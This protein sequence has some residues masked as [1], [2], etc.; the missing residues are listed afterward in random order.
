M[1]LANDGAIDGWCIYPDRPDE[2]ATVEFLVN[3]KVV[4]SMRA[5][6]LRLDRRDLGVGDG[7]CGFSFP[8]TRASEPDGGRTI[9]EVRERRLNTFI[10]RVILGQNNVALERRL[11]AAAS[12]LTAVEKA[13]VN[14]R[15]NSTLVDMTNDLGAALLYL[16]GRTKGE[17][18]LSVPGLE[19]SLGKITNIPAIDLGWRRVPRFSVIIHATGELT[20]LAGRIRSIAVALE[21]LGAEFVLVDDG[22]TPLMALLPTRLRHLSLIRIARSYRPGMAKNAV[23]AAARGEFLVY[24]RPGGPRAADLRGALDGARAGKLDID[25]NLT[26]S[27][28][29]T[30]ENL[31]GH[32]LECIVA[33]KDFIALGGFDPAR[34]EQEMWTNFVE[35]AQALDL[36][37]APWAALRPGRLLAG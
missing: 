23:A 3:G 16:S 5:T 17:R 30:D 9:L 7:Y 15:D 31:A 34:G 21:G 1:Y 12:A 22:T 14:S 26:H 10:G 28:T 4:R 2:R 24:A 11:E 32:G 6:R 25:S 8:F 13:L 29:V 27:P 18:T 35:K 19:A 33:R 36:K 37:I 20:A